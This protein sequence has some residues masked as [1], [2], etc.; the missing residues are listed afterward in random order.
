MTAS[1]FGTAAV[2]QPAVN[3]VSRDSSEEVELGLRRAMNS[4][5]VENGSHSS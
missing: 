4:A 1:R 3:T 2:E 5:G